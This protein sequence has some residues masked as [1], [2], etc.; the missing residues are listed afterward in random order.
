M[1]KVKQFSLQVVCKNPRKREKRNEP[2][3]EVHRLRDADHRDG[4]EHVVADLGNLQKRKRERE[5]E[6][7][8]E[9]VCM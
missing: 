3:A 2:H 7:E 5:R 6:R 8:R 9:S 4:K 1:I